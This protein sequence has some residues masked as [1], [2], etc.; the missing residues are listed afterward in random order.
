M[1]DGRFDIGCEA[2]PAPLRT[3]AALSETWP[4]YSRTVDLLVTEAAVR[5]LH[6]EVSEEARQVQT[7]Q[8]VV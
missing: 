8:V 1:T 3:L 2:W 4:S 5:I 6:T 7:G